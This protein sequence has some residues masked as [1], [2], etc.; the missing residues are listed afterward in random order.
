[1]SPPSTTMK[2]LFFGFHASPNLPTFSPNDRPSSS[3]LRALGR[4]VGVRL[5]PGAANDILF[6]AQSGAARAT[7]CERR[8]RSSVSLFGCGSSPARRLPRRKAYRRRGVI[9]AAAEA[10]RPSSISRSGPAISTPPPT[11]AAVRS[12]FIPAPAMCCFAARRRTTLTRR[13]TS[14]ARR[15]SSR[16]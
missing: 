7:S 15:H 13:A 3:D 8:V 12:P 5:C 14:P 9:S 1:M 4:L 10:A 2:P 16:C 11:A 6:C